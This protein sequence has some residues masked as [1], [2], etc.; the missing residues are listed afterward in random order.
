MARDFLIRGG[1]SDNPKLAEELG[2]LNV[3]WAALELRIFNLFEVLTG[4]SVPVARAIYYSL[5][6]TAAR[7]VVVKAVAQVALRRRKRRHFGVVS[8]LGEPIAYQKRV[9]NILGDIGRMSGDRNKFVHD[10]WVGHETSSRAYQLRLRGKEIHGNYEP[11]RI[12]DIRSFVLKVETKSASLKKLYDFL[13]PKMLP[14][15]DTLELQ[16]ALTLVPATKAPRPKKK[17]AKPQHRPR[18]SRR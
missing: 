11:V 7:I 17:K 2:Q 1:L 10:P 15:L 13:A 6:T 3:A 8:K 5:N 14:L 4:L 16:H 18:S 9:T 12:R